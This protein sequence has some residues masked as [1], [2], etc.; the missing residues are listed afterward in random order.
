MNEFAILNYNQTHDELSPN[1]IW[2]RRHDE[3]RV[4]DLNDGPVLLS[5]GFKG[6]KEEMLRILRKHLKD[7][8]FVSSESGRI[9]ILFD[10]QERFSHVLHR[11]KEESFLLLSAGEVKKK[12]LLPELR[13]SGGHMAANCGMDG[14]TF[15]EDNSTGRDIAERIRSQYVN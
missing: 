1:R 5:G 9:Y 6:G 11:R 12:D 8:T 4:V 2:R 10:T 14:F 15:T 13:S 3:K 7:T